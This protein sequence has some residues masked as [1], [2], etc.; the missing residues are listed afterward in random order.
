MH[1]RIK[2]Q[3]NPAKH[4]W[5]FWRVSKVSRSVFQGGGRSRSPIFSE[6][7]YWAIPHFEKTKASHRAVGIWSTFNTFCSIFTRWRL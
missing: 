7:G 3:P 5:V 4:G 2:F 1:H 6:T